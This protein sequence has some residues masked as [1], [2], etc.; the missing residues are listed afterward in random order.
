MKLVYIYG[1]PTV[2]KLEVAKQLAKITGFKLFHNHLTADYV[3]SI[4]PS[5][6]KISN[7]LK[8]EIASKIF[9]AAAKQGVNLIFTK[10]YDSS[11]KNFVKNVIKIIE[12]HG[13]EVLFVKLYCEPK[14]LYERV[15]KN[16]RKA[17]DKIKTIKD[18]KIALKKNNKFETIPFKKSLIMDNTIIS[19]KECAQKIKEYYKL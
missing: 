8:C 17:F 14:N 1:P 5:K 12:K 2:G 3:S 10:V 15:T 13:G 9:E 6:D 16:S 19:P 18:L 11:D 4:F 7:K